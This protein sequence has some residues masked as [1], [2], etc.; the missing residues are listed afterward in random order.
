MT[1]F[2]RL[3]LSLAILL[4]T[5][6]ASMFAGTSDELHLTSVPEGAAVFVANKQVGTTP[7]TVSISR[8]ADDV[9]FDHP[10]YGK[11]V[12]PLQSSFQIGYLL[13]DVLFTPGFGLSGILIDS[14]TQA[15]WDHPSVV[16]HDF[17]K[18]PEEKKKKNEVAADDPWAGS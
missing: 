10:K 3:L 9:T 8:S 12:V 2:A 4:S 6:C 14:M 1:T 15:W 13:L 18:P 11:R 16:T 7:C 17:T 5:S